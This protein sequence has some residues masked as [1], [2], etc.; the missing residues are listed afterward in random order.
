MK[1]Q[2]TRNDPH[3]DEQVEILGCLLFLMLYLGIMVALYSF[4]WHLFR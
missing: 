4:P 2:A 1:S 3:R